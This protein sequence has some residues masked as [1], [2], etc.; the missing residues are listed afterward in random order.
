MR[1]SRMIAARGPGMFSGPFTRDE[2]CRPHETHLRIR[3]WGGQFL[4]DSSGHTRGSTNS[5]ATSGRWNVGPRQL[6]GGMPCAIPRRI[7]RQDRYLLRGSRRVTHVAVHVRRCG[8]YTQERSGGVGRRGRTAA[9]DLYCIAVDGKATGSSLIRVPPSAFRL[10]SSA[11][12][13][14]HP[15][16]INLQS[17]N[18]PSAIPNLQCT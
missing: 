4:Q 10:P 15:S 2:T 16:A 6:P 11:F 12:R 1:I 3:D 5:D 7:H 18:P 13:L 17:M 8:T 14:I 9:K